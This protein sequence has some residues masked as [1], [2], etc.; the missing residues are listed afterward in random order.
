MFVFVNHKY[1][2]VKK[3]FY[4]NSWECVMSLKNFIT[5]INNHPPP[6]FTTSHFAAPTWPVPGL[7]LRHAGVPLHWKSKTHFRGRGSFIEVRNL[8]KG[9]KTKFSIPL[10]SD[11]IISWLH[12]WSW[13][14]QGLKCPL[15]L[16]AL[17]ITVWRWMWPLARIT[18]RSRTLTA[19]S[20]NS[21]WFVRILDSNLFLA[22]FGLWW[23]IVT[24]SYDTCNT[25]FKWWETQMFHLLRG[26]P[27]VFT[28]K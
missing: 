10:T 20:G 17:K 2:A 13:I 22:G 8:P 6:V 5:V 16:P 21:T 26:W 25:F 1:R 14:P 12:R 23:V 19:S 4:P 27:M 9:S 7:L 28:T 11:W 15:Q 3:I 18:L 24:N